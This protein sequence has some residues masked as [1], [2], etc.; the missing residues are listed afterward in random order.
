[1][2]PFKYFIKRAYLNNDLAEMNCSV[3]DLA[4]ESLDKIQLKK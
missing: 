2:I 1:M 4:C 3:A